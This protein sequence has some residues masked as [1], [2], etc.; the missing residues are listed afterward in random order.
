MT[1]YNAYEIYLA[2]R[3][4]F[5]KPQ[6]D[7]FKY[8]GKVKTNIESFNKRKDRYFFEKLSR[9]KT[10]KDIINF[11]VSNFISY[12][13]PS[14]IWIGELKVKGDSN[15]LDWKTRTQSL[16]YTF[17]EDLNSIL[18]EYHLYEVLFTENNSHP[19]IVKQY[20][21]KKIS[22]ETITILDDITNFS[23][24]LNT[25]DPVL[26]GL[27]HKIKKYKP[28]LSYDKSLFIKEI[29]SRL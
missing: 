18:R 16:S 12:S 28:F 1:A 21:G 6:Y 29:K 3:L 13:D 8:S 9:K 5:T 20:L 14:K 23:A 22:L 2:L 10:E 11:F 7:F 17:K 27:T 25:L 15:F 19:K 24:R 4:H 26:S